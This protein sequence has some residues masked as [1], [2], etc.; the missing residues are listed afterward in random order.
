VILEDLELELS[1]PGQEIKLHDIEVTP[2]VY[3]EA[4]LIAAYREIE[5]YSI[6]RIQLVDCI[7]GANEIV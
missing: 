1:S 7:I 4:I 5:L 3:G 2:A 6:F